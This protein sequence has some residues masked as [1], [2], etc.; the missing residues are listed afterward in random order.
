M[1]PSLLFFVDPV[2]VMKHYTGC[3]LNTKHTGC[4]GYGL[5]ET[6]C[7]IHQKPTIDI[8][9]EQYSNLPAHNS[10]ADAV[11]QKDIVLDEGFQ[12]YLKDSFAKKTIIPI[13]ELFGKKR[14][15]AMATQA[16]LTRKVP[17]GWKEDN[18]TSFHPNQQQKFTGSQGG[19]QYGPT[20]A[21]RSAVH[22]GESI[23]DNQ[24]ANMFL[25]FFPVACLEE[26][27]GQ[28]TK[29][30]REDWVTKES[31]TSQTFKPCTDINDPNKRHC[32]HDDCCDWR[33]P[34]WLVGC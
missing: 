16:E 15:N 29:Y 24:L 13:D 31:P 6:W 26:I 11:A 14:Q 27:A 22:N 2:T 32:L 20:S 28:T 1:P 3:K 23:T 9:I 21:M 12:K 18:T 8:S 19:D 33:G 10:L 17:P 25:F 30:A 4:N 7:H 34:S 5:E